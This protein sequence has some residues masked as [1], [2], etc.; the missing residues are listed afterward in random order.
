MDQM[1]Q[2]DQAKDQRMKWKSPFAELKPVQVE[3]PEELGVVTS[4]LELLQL[5]YRNPAVPLS[6]RMRAA[7]E[8][9]PFEHP[10]L[11]ATAI[12]ESGDFALRLDK[13]IERSNAAR[14]IEH[15]PLASPDESPS[16]R[17]IPAVGPTPTP[18]SAPFA[19]RRRG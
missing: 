8:A 11:S 4:S 16:P 3:E 14:V 1:D 12:L 5:V 9:L 13:A 7:V 10:K 6:V 15:R 19:T 2:M 17:P 18:M